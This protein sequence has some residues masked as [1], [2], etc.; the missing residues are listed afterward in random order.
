[1]VEDCR[2]L[3]DRDEEW[4]APE[5]EKNARKQDYCPGALDSQ[6]CKIGK[7]PRSLR[8][9]RSIVTVSPACRRNELWSRTWRSHFFWDSV[10]RRRLEWAYQPSSG[11]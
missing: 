3:Y 5:I 7:R 11:L 10:Y 4:L 1:M 8:K 2:E 9:C 6:V